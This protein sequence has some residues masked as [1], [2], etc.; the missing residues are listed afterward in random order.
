[1]VIGD[2]R[3]NATAR[4]SG[5]KLVRRLAAVLA[6]DIVGYSAMMGRN[7][8]R[9]HRRV[10]VELK[11]IAK[12]IA[13][14]KGR[15]FSFAGDGLMAEF[16]SAV[17]A[18]RCALRMRAESRKRNARLS[19]KD[20]IRFRIGI[21]SGEIIVHNGCTGG[22]AVNV[23][24]RLEQA[25]DADS[26]YLSQAV[27]DQVN[28]MV[29]ADYIWVGERRLK[30]IRD[31]VTIYMISPGASAARDTGSAVQDHSSTP[32]VDLSADYRPS[33]AILPF[34]TSEAERTEAYFAEG[35]VDD[36]VRMLGG[37]KDLI[38]VSRSSTIGYAGAAPDLQKISRE[39]NVSYVLRG[40]VRRAED[41][42]RIAVELVDARTQLLIWA[43]RFDGHMTDIFDLQ[44][45]IAVRTASL[46][47]PYVREQELR[48]ASYKDRNTLT[49]YDLT[50]QALDQLYVRDPSALGRAQ[51]LLKRAIG[52][53]SHYSTALTHLA[54]LQIFR[55]GQGWSLNEHE[56][57]LTAAE[58]AKLAVQR[59]HNDALALAIYGHLRGF[60]HKEHEAALTILEQAIAIGPS[61]A[62]AWSFSSYVCGWM[63]DPAAAVE[64]ARQGLRLSPIGPDA[65]CWHEHALSQAH[66]M[67]GEFDEAIVWAKRAASHGRQ[68]SNLR[69]LAAS[70][71]AS[72]RL[73][74]ARTV[75]HQ[76]IRAKPDF[77]LKVY[78]SQT[79]LSGQIADLFIERLRR[80]GLPD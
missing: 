38:V 29:P 33:L 69:C 6:W 21:N 62:L 14:A 12:D 46:I 16:P 1:M 3:P 24:A 4:R 28:R 67:A 47:A 20:Q 53:D 42:V 75:A 45:R 77:H 55:I 19:T 36:I 61:C 13:R 72:D 26:I 32:K 78:R 31:S 63:G 50:L 11:R 65:G 73:A 2:N 70:L 49:A 8:E 60:L 59:D 58:A 5:Q 9:T 79:P 57:R 39:L 22:N 48:R 71:V 40:S 34:R 10:N 66:Y 41:Q 68:Q 51:D 35:M 76:I 27:F 7:E 44:D 15:I 23:A 43:D 64:R 52:L 25:A 30:N 80:A 18:V 17:E 74:E 56:D 37:L 54:Y